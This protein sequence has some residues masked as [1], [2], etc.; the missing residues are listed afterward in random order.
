MATSAPFEAKYGPPDYYISK[1]GPF[2][3]LPVY[4]Q[5]L[6]TLKNDSDRIAV[7]LIIIHHEP[8]RSAL[9]VALT[10]PGP[11]DHEEVSCKA[12]VL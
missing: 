6:K 12:P 7:N 3:G 2:L 9:S 1:Q 5:A 11:R 8:G 10:S 4:T